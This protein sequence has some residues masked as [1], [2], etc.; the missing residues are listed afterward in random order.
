MS[1]RKTRPATQAV[2]LLPSINP[3]FAASPLMQAGK[4]L[5]NYIL[6]S[7]GNRAWRRRQKK[8]HLLPKASQYVATLYA[9]PCLN[10]RKTNQAKG[11][12]GQTM[13]LKRYVTATGGTHV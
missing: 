4:K 10:D 6:D 7:H 8:I 11:R 12:R 9:H 5:G 13:S 1:A 3:G 2:H